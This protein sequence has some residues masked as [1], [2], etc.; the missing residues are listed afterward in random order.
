MPAATAPNAAEG[1]RL[2]FACP[3]CQKEVLRT[4]VSAL[5][6]ALCPHCRGALILDPESFVDA[7][8]PK[9]KDPRHDLIETDAAG[10]PAKPA[11]AVPRKRPSARMAARRAAADD[12]EAQV[13]TIA[14]KLP[15]GRMSRQKT[16]IAEQQRAFR[17]GQVRVHRLQVALWALALL[18][19]ITIL[20]GSALES[21]SAAPRSSLMPQLVEAG[22]AFDRAWRD[23]LDLAGYHG[24]GPRPRQP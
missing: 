15:S 8:R 24:Q 7:R 3:H 18:A 14:E 2:R 21:K 17:R 4:V 11:A 23:L 20:L 12:P 10:Q 19:T 5:A 22:G 13:E 9:T 1:L 6:L 16:L